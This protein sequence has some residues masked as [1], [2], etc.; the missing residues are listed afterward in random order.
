M[1]LVI[2]LRAAYPGI[3]FSMLPDAADCQLQDDGDGAYIAAWNRAEPKPNEAE[4]LANFDL[5][6]YENRRLWAAQ[7]QSRK[8]RDA[9][10]ALALPDSDDPKILKQKLNAALALL[11]VR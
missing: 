7:A 1:S 9:R 8:E 6:L 2:A 11:N 10:N 3:T 4:L 5:A